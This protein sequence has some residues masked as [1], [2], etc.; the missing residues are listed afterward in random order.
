[1]K[2]LAEWLD[3]FIGHR[4][5][6]A[7][8]GS[9]VGHGWLIADTSSSGAPT[10]V[11]ATDGR[12]LK[13]DFSNASEVQNLCASFGDRLAFDIDEL[14]EIRLRVKMNQALVNAATSFACGLCSARNDDPDALAA[15]A[16]FRVIGADST[17]AIV[18]ETDDGVIDLDDKATGMTLGAVEKDL[19]I[20]FAT[21]KGDVRF[22]IDGQP[23]AASVK[24]DMSNY[25]GLLQPYFQ[26][27]KTAATATDGF[28]A[29][30]VHVKYRGE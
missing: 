2:R 3:Q 24:F 9:N 28:T 25:S 30:L 5:Y 27:Q 29:R 1:M 7:T 22:F 12:G 10:Y 20:S 18:V 16:S 26:L 8:A 21:G 11:P 23:V 19:L 14:Q 17:T 4:V 13:V 6:S 15:H